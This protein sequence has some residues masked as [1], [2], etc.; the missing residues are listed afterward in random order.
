MMIIFIWLALCVVIAIAANARGR[1]PAG[2]GFL[3]LFASPL[4]AG[5][6]LFAFPSLA[7]EP[8]Q[9]A[10]P[11]RPEGVMGGVPYR[12]RPNGSIE[13]MMSGGIVRFATVEQFRAATAGADYIPRP[14]DPSPDVDLPSV[15]NGTAYRIEPDHSIVA[16]M[17]GELR[18][19]PN[20]KAF[21]LEIHKDRTTG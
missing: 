9:Q 20:W 7:L 13:A 18:N 8:P 19:F 10:E 12:V 1:N 6:L 11:F 15:L 5:I 2:W 17:G 21:W 4:V 14:N 3:A 16:L